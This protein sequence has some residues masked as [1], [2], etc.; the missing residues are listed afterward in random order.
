MLL[1]PPGAGK[2]TQAVRLVEELGIPQVSTGDLL[3]A[4]RRAGTILGQKAQSY[5][6]A[7]KLVPDELVIQLVQERLAADDA[8]GGYILDGFPRN[9]SQAETLVECRIELERVVNIS[10][11]DEALVV[12]LSGRRICRSCGGS[13]HVDFQPTVVDGTCDRC[14]G[15]TYQRNDDRPDV[16]AQRLDVYRE[17]TEPLIAFYTD[18][19]LL[20][21]VDGDGRF[22]EVYGRIRGALAG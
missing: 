12:R 20:R 11:H 21:S 9:E 18:A 10:V 3:R 16:I 17:Q 7:G 6:D 14:G 1:G 4:A 22:E 13:Y 19:G 2:G 8:S 15:E 5:M